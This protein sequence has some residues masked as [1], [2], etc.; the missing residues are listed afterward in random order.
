MER[1]EIDSGAPSEEFFIAEE[2]ELEFS[3]SAPPSNIWP[4]DPPVDPRVFPIVHQ[5]QRVSDEENERYRQFQHAMRGQQ[6]AQLQREQAEQE[7]LR[8]QRE[9]DERSQPSTPLLGSGSGCREEDMEIYSDGGPTSEPFG[10]CFTEPSPT[11]ISVST[12]NLTKSVAGFKNRSMTSLQSLKNKESTVHKWLKR[13]CVSLDFKGVHFLKATVIFGFV[14]LLVVLGYSF[15]PK[16][17]PDGDSM[18]RYEGN[19]TRNIEGNVMNYY[20]KGNELKTY[21]QYKSTYEVKSYD[22]ELLQ[23]QPAESYFLRS[24]MR[25]FQCEETKWAENFVCCYDPK[26]GTACASQ[27]KNNDWMLIPGF[28]YRAEF[29]KKNGQDYLVAQERFNTMPYLMDRMGEEIPIETHECGDAYNVLRFDITNEKIAIVSE[30][31]PK[32]KNFTRSLLLIDPFDEND[33]KCF[34]GEGLSLEK[35]HGIW[36]DRDV[37]WMLSC[38]FS[39]SVRLL[40]LEGLQPIYYYPISQHGDFT[41]NSNT[42]KHD[43]RVVGKTENNYLNIYTFVNGND[44]AKIIRKRLSFPD[45]NPKN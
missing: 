24:V 17:D 12:K 3:G 27:R 15:W 34:Q 45:N 25:Q 22:Y 16:P 14:V 36:V 2:S 35:L 1:R 9:N 38:S 37:V 6:L 11:T 8:L 7:A 10:N 19:L 23:I 18:L 30:K 33:H 29:L 31:K 40:T 44:S 13:V 42:K 21:I 4:Y 32:D 26:Y 28:F 20:W 5:W 41:V 43:P 39:C